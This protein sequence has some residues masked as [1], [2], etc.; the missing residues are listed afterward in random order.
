VFSFNGRSNRLQFLTTLFGI[1]ILTFV[2]MFA[3]YGQ[4]GVIGETVLVLSLAVMIAVGAPVLVRRGHDLGW[5]ARLPLGLVFG[6]LA[7]S[8]LGDAINADWVEFGG[9]IVCNLTIFALLL[10]LG[11]RG[12]NRFG[13][14]PHT[15]PR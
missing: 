5:P 15:V 1:S 10:A 9:V 12:A 2:P 4:T 14:A 3:G 7:V 11:D 8:F 13:Q 6:G